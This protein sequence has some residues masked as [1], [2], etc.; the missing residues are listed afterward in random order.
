MCGEYDH[1][2]LIDKSTLMTRALKRV[3][4]TIEAQEKKAPRTK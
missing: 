4:A 1:L 3:E 2:R